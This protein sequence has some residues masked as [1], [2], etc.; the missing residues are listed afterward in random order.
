MTEVLVFETN[1]LNL[2]PITYT[3]TTF[4]ILCGGRRQLERIVDAFGENVTFIVRDELFEIF[5]WRWKTNV[6]ELPD[7]SSY[8]F[9]N[10]SFLLTESELNGLKNSL[11][12]NQ[13]LIGSHGVVAFK[14]DKS[15]AEEIFKE[16]TINKTFLNKLF[17]KEYRWKTRVIRY[18]WDIINHLNELIVKDL[19]SSKKKFKRREADKGGFPVYIGENVTI[20]KCVFFDCSKGPVVIED[21]V[22]IQSFSRI[23]GPTWIKAG[24]IILSA[25]V[26]GGNVIGEVCKVGGEIEE[27]IIEGYSNKAHRSYLGHSYVGE[28]VNIGALTVTSDLKNT[29]GTIKMHI[30]GKKVDTGRIKLGA[31]IADYAKTSILTAI[32]SGRKIGVASHVYGVVYEDVPSFTIWA[33]TLGL[34]PVELRLE[35]AINTQRRM[36]R[37]RNVTQKRVHI[38]LLER[39]Y[40]ETEKERKEHGVLKEKLRF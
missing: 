18:L 10:G 19:E 4:E 11:D 7:S 33:K 16:K 29:Y 23:S 39:I 2:L 40:K 35:S 36:F 37:R 20:E 22:E 28:W 30:N 26:R 27:S 13:A 31:F 25:L 6:N 14:V 38:K 12:L 5:N 24:S 34:I 1:Q 3:R 17:K 32:F 21:G 9:I 15:K 8:L